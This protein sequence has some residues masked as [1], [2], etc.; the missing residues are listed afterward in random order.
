MGNP[1]KAH[2]YRVT[3]AKS[4]ETAGSQCPMDIRM[5]IEGDLG[6]SYIEVRDWPKAERHTQH[7]VNMAQL[8]EDERAECLY[9][10]NLGLVHCKICFD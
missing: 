9:K 3:A 10:T 7:A 2:S 5:L 8:L 4:A 6:R 1:H